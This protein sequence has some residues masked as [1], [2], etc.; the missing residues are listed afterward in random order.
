M[1]AL[2]DQKS[3]LLNSFYLLISTTYTFDLVMSRP[4]IASSIDSKDIDNLT[5][6]I[7]TQNQENSS[8]RISNT[9]F[10]IIPTVTI[11]DK[12]INLYLEVSTN[13]RRGIITC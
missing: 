7:A 13:A 1:W 4:Q 8:L 11:T 9:P 2:L 12:Y 5:A 6:Y 3:A 10:C